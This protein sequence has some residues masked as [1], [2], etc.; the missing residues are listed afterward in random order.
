MFDIIKKMGAISAVVV[1]T[2]MFASPA[3]AITVDMEP[4]E[5]V[6]GPLNGVHDLSSGNTFVFDGKIG[7]TEDSTLSYS[8]DFEATDLPQPAY[9]L[10]IVAAYFGQGGGGLATATAE[11]VVTG[12]PGTV[13]SSIVLDELAEGV[14][15]SGSF[16]TYF[17]DTNPLQ[18]LII[19]FTGLVGG[20]ES[21]SLDVSVSAVPVPPALLLFGTSIFGIGL[22]SYRRRRKTGVSAA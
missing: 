20:P 11:W 3:S 12:D 2:A 10:D 5:Y 4:N 7:A 16:L 9:V 19:S 13:L 15:W 21:I 22:L 14:L 18:T 17:N 8:F 1:A 6:A